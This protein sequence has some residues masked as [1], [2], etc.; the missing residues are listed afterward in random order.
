MKVTHLVA[1]LCE[2]A[3]SPQ[4]VD[5]QLLTLASQIEKEGISAGDAAG[6]EEGLLV[7]LEQPDGSRA[8]EMAR[9]T[10]TKGR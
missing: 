5:Q 7:H 1:V 10:T 6:F 2:L 9:L 3:E 4:C 8:P